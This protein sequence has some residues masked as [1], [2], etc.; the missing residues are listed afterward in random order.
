MNHY[1][2]FRTCPIRLQGHIKYLFLT[3]RPYWTLCYAFHTFGSQ[4]IPLSLRTTHTTVNHIKFKKGPNC[5]FQSQNRLAHSDSPLGNQYAFY[6][7][8]G[9]YANAIHSLFESIFL[10]IASIL[11][12]DHHIVSKM[13]ASHQGRQNLHCYR[14]RNIKFT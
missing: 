4:P 10:Y 3:F 14:T 8:V 1:S 7:L 9:S 2:D 5:T 13:Y 11:K 6:K 12:L